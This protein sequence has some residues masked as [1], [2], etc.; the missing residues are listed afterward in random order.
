MT[1][2]QQRVGNLPAAKTRMVG[3]RTEL[4]GI[5]R[6]FA[7]T[8]QLVT[9]TGVGGVGK[10]RLA[11]EAARAMQPRFRDGAWLVELSPLRQGELLAHTLAEA[12]PLADQTTRPMIDVLA[13]YLADRE[14]LLVLDTCEHLADACALTVQALARAAPGLR[15]LAT[16]RRPLDAPGEEVITVEPL[17]VPET[18]DPAAA[19]ADAVVLLAERAAQSVPGF[20]VSEAGRAELVRLSRRLEGLPLAIELAAARL[21]ELSV[22]ELTERLD[23]RFAVLGETDEAVDGAEP[24]SSSRLLPQPSAGRGRQSGEGPPWHQALR[25]AIGW[26]H[27]LCSPA[28]RLLWARLSVF[29]GSFDAEAARLVCADAALAAERIPALLT[30]LVDTSI[31]TWWPTGGGER[32][33]MLDTLREYGAGWLCNL[34][35]EDELC[36]RHRDHYRALAHRA[37]AAWMGP[38]QIAWHQRTVTEHANLRAALDFCLAE[39]DGHAALE[40]GGE[41]WFLW[42]ACGFSKEGR[43]YLDR[44]LAL[45]PAAGPARA[46]ALWASGLIAIVQGDAETLGRVAGTFRTAVAGEIDE[47]APYAAAYLEGADFT[48]HG[49]MTQTAE[50]LDAAPGPRPAGGRY[51]AGWFL[52]RTIRA[53][54]HVTWGSSPM[55]RP[56]PMTCV[57]SAPGAARP[58]PTPGPTTCVPSPRSGWGARRRLRTMPAPPWRASVACTTASASPWSWTCWPP[59]PSPPG[60]PSGLPGSWAAPSRSGTPSVCR[61][62]ASPNS[63]PPARSARP[64]PAVFSGTTPTR[65]RSTPAITPPRHRHRLRPQLFR[66]TPTVFLVHSGQLITELCS[67]LAPAADTTWGLQLPPVPTTDPIATA[68]WPKSRHRPVRS[69]LVNIRSTQGRQLLCSTPAPSLLLHVKKATLAL[70]LCAG[71]VLRWLWESPSDRLSD[72][73]LFDVTQGLAVGRWGITETQRCSCP[74]DRAKGP[75]RATCDSRPGLL[76]PAH[77]CAAT[78]PTTKATPS[79]TTCLSPTPAAPGEPYGVCEA[80]A[81]P[82]GRTSRLPSETKTHRH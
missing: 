46:K 62:W 72:V 38:D 51:R 4:R 65:A 6:L 44:A 8:A 24:P 47:S 9:L 75:S 23:D 39:E 81:A 80:G 73:G 35:E 12:L 45:A 34:G 68:A 25:T 14:L 41:L 71:V 74:G 27:Q 17:P 7:G 52:A 59:W 70:Y 43:H 78:A 2:D 36:R 20:T 56:S 10:T 63:W 42:F 79:P 15:I 67:P 61:R 60:T 31:L 3:R 64:R 22:G 18:D 55:P 26:S 5:L 13:D 54:A 76:D 32:Y 49:R 57:P 28:E 69:S 58:G 50:V 19:Q 16:S 53:F 48:M 66:R 33:R 37:D 77:C 21:G 1:G 40:M 29:A 82:P 11:L 30:A